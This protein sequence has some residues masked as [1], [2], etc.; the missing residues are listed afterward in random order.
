MFC[1][2]YIYSKA[3]YEAVVYIFFGAL[4]A[5]SDTKKC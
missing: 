2:L 1:Y 3:E 4:S 5:D